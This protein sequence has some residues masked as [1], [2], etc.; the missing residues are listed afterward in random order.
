MEVAT[1]RHRAGEKGQGNREM[2]RTRGSQGRKKKGKRGEERRC[3][4]LSC[5]LKLVCGSPNA[6]APQNVTLLGNGVIVEAVS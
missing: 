2:E 5:S 6:L 1:E 3:Y 4:R